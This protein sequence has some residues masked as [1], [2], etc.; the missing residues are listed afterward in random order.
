[1]GEVPGLPI[2]DIRRVLSIGEV[3]AANYEPHEKTELL[4]EKALADFDRN[5]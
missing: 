2:S 1:L 5:L 3:E 4:I